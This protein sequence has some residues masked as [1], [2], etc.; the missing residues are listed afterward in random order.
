MLPDI[1]QIILAIMNVKLYGCILTFRKV[2]N[3]YVGKC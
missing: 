3:R 1:K 2:A